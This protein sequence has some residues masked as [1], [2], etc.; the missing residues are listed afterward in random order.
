MTMDQML[1]DKDLIREED[2]VYLPPFY[3]AE[4]GTANKLKRLAAEPAQDRLW[5][6]LSRARR[7][8]GNDMM[9]LRRRT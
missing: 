3:Y 1:R 8:T 6:Q 2:A 4:T 5:A 7:D 9:P